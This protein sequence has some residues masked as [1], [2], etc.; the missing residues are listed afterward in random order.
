MVNAV[1]SPTPAVPAKKAE[2]K[3]EETKPESNP[4]AP[5]RKPNTG[6]TGSGDVNTPTGGLDPKTN[7]AVTQNIKKPNTGN[8][9]DNS[10]SEAPK[11]KDKPEKKD[12][13]DDQPG[14]LG[15]EKKDDKDDRG[16]GIEEKMTN[17][18]AIDILRDDD[19]AGLNKLDVAKDK[20]KNGKE[21][22]GGDQKLSDEDFNLAIGE[23]GYL[24]KEEKEAA[25]F[26]YKEGAWDDING[27]DTKGTYDEI[28]DYYDSK[29]AKD[30][31]NGNTGSVLDEIDVLKQ[32]YNNGIISD[33]QPD[34]IIS[35]GDLY[36]ATGERSPL[37]K[38]DRE[39]A[40]TLVTS[41]EWGELNGKDNKASVD[42]IVDFGKETDNKELAKAIETLSKNFISG[43]DR[44]KA[45]EKES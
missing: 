5:E 19:N 31:P 20:I 40:M 12:E 41:D 11:S 15:I 38:E 1:G 30:D 9:G 2:G 28:D 37:G 44:E 45:K 34:G 36:V 21:D 18:E 7:F 16:L 3:K 24:T 32:R 27:K 25:E 42:E 26:L 14:V 10:P 13:K 29:T 22:P 33:P 39:A 23:E 17:R 8:T 4:P 35:T 43:Y 6:N